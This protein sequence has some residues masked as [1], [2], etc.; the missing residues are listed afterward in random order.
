MWIITTYLNETANERY[1]ARSTA[2]SDYEGRT[3]ATVTQASSSSNASSGCSVKWNYNWVSGWV[4]GG[5]TAEP[6]GDQGLCR[7]TAHWHT[8][9][10]WHNRW[11]H[12]IHNRSNKIIKIGSLI[13]TYNRHNY[14]IK[15]PSWIWLTH[16]FGWQI[17][18]LMRLNMC[19]QLAC[20][21]DQVADNKSGI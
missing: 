21:T 15:I 2:P 6:K 16:R 3:K 17:L 10:T 5:L 20:I 9:E 8:P 19:K 7:I 1:L 11:S 4:V 14:I 12:P 18:S 13:C